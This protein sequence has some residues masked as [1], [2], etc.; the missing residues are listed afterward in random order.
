MQILV[1]NDDGIYAPGIRVLMNTL[2]DYGNIIVVAPNQECSGV[3]HAIT[4]NRPLRIE[5]LN[6]FSEIEYCY[7]INGTPADCVKYAVESLD[8]DIDLVVSGINIG[9]NLG[10]DVLY[11]GTVSAAMEGLLHSIPSVAVSLSVNSENPSRFLE[12]AAHYLTNV[13]FKANVSLSDY[14]LLNINVPGVPQEQVKGI[15]AT[16]LGINGY[17]NEFEQRFDP[18]GKPYYWMKGKMAENISNGE[19]DLDHLAVMDNFVSVT[20]IKY[21]LTNYALLKQL[22]NHFN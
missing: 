18:R 8:I 21:D 7:M 20:P 11:S 12:T 2:K 3:G 5:K 15:K 13:I 10:T 9:A 1:T 6:I 22:K 17:V 19:Q 16:K 14:G 4:V